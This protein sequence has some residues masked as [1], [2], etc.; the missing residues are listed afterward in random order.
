MTGSSQL[1]TTDTSPDTPAV[2]AAIADDGSRRILSAADTPQ[3][4][5]EL[6]N[7]CE[8]PLS[9]TYRKIDR[10]T[11]AGLL[12]ESIHI[13]EDGHRV[14]RFTRTFESLEFSVE[15]PELVV[16]LEAANR[17]S[18]GGRDRSVRSLGASD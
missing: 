10:L 6:A 17:D 2:C 5:A 7:S 14:S 9:S 1:K 16:K 8:I 13:R 11:A 12:A 18:P 3:T 15:G 4:A